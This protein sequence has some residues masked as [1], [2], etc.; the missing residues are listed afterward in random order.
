M[1]NS[2]Y[3]FEILLLSFGWLLC[4]EELLKSFL[5]GRP[6][7]LQCCTIGVAKFAL[8]VDSSYTLPSL[9]R[10]CPFHPHISE[11]TPY[12][13]KK[14]SMRMSKEPFDSLFVC[15]VKIFTYKI[16]QHWKKKT[17]SETICTVF[18]MYT[19][20]SFWF[21]FWAQTLKLQKVHTI[22]VNFQVTLFTS[23]QLLLTSICTI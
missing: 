10:V 17:V 8:H 12:P 19:A 18:C 21:W 23:Y 1:L 3:M 11:W 7:T 2:H 16:V 15:S 22:F 9:I 5:S 6:W 4:P 14:S 20:D 13:Y